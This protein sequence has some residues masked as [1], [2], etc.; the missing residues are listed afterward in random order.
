VAADALATRAAPPAPPDLRRIQVF[1]RVVRREFAD[2]TLLWGW[3]ALHNAEL[4][5]LTFN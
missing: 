2:G 4:N 1:V 5:S 3:R